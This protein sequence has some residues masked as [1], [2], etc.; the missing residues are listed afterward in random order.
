MRLLE[1]LLGE[2][3]GAIKLLLKGF[4]KGRILGPE[5]RF[6]LQEILF[7]QLS[8]GSNNGRHEIG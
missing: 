1:R 7:G 4:V 3:P 5:L 6:V 8:K 2:K